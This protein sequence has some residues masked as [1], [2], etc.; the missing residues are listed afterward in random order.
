[1]AST[2]KEEGAANSMAKAGGLRSVPSGPALRTTPSLNGRGLDL[3]LYLAVT[4]AAG[5]FDRLGFSL[6]LRPT[7]TS[8]PGVFDEGLA[9]HAAPQEL[10]S[11]SG[12][13]SPVGV[14]LSSGRRARHYLSFRELG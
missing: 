6:V 8:A 5:D 12:E 7:A 1:M 2:E 3:P 4:L 13:S 10:L 11:F 9:V 14:R